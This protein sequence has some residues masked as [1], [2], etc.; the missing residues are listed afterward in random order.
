MVWKVFQKYLKAGGA[1]I[2][3]SKNVQE[4]EI[5]CDRIGLIVSGRLEFIGTPDE[6]NNR[7]L[8]GYTIVFRLNKRYLIATTE[9]INLITDIRLKMENILG[10]CVFREAYHVMS[11]Y[12]EY[13][14]LIQI[15]YSTYSTTVID[16][17]LLKK[18]T[19]K[20]TDYCFSTDFRT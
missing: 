11:L 16:T 4:C 17:H 1:I 8:S 12:L 6:I 13:L 18:G 15:I 19:T 7:F 5:M 9:D 10:Q 3:A 20:L 14:T 2:L